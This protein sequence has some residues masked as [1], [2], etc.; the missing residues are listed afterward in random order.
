[1]YTTRIHPVFVNYYTVLGQKVV[2][3]NVATLRSGLCYCK[4]VC[5]RLTFVRPTQGVETFGNISSLFVPKP[6]FDLRAKFYGDRPRGTPVGGVKRKT[7]SKI[8]RCHV[9]V[10]H[11]PMSF[12]YFLKFSTL[13]SFRPC[14]R[15]AYQSARRYNVVRVRR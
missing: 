5:L 15:R 2:N 1:M 14:S 6:S 12:L 3:P 8:E 11:L 7:G 4:S 13:F 9:R 10:S